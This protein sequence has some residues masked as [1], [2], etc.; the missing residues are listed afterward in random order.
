MA[1]VCLNHGHLVNNNL[2][3][4]ISFSIGKKQIYGHQSILIVRCPKLINKEGAEKAKELLIKG[5]KK[6]RIIF[7]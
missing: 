6:E 3:A 5:K 1:D 7:Y 2:Y 4:D